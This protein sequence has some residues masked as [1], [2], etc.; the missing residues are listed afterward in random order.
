VGQ[1]KTAAQIIAQGLHDAG[2]RSAFGIPGGEVLTI[3]NALEEAGIS[4]VLTKHENPAGFMAEGTHHV[5]GAPGI[6]VAT[7]GPGVANAVNVVANA[8]QDRVPLIFLTGR[9]DPVDEQTYT[10]QV[11]DHGRLLDS[12]VK[13]SFTLVSGAVGTIVEKAVA[14]ATQGRPGPVHI[15]VPVSLAAEVQSSDLV[16]KPA[17]HPPLQPAESE[18]L[19]GA[20]DAFAAAT[21]PLLIVGLEAV[22]QGCGETI[23]GFA[24]THGIPVITTYKA[25]GLLPESDPLCLGA[26]GLSPLADKQLLPLVG[27]AD[28]ILL[29]GYDP[30][31]MRHG[32]KNPWNVEKTSVVE[33]THETHLHGVHRASYVFC[34]DIA[35]GLSVVT[36]GL[37]PR[38]SWPDGRPAQVRGA[39][40]DSFANNDAWGPAAIIQETRRA[41]PVDGIA[42]VDSGAHRILLSQIWPCEVPGTL[43]Q[44]TGLCTMGCALP[45]A[46]GAKLAAPDRAVVAF[47]G[48]AGL[49]M[50]LGEVAT[51]RDLRLPVVVVVFVDASLALIEMKQRNSGFPNQGVDFGKSDFAGLARVFGGQGFDV[52]TREEMRAALSNALQ[53]ETFSI[54]AA[55]IDAKAYDGTF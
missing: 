30:I 27:D 39:I 45:L 14:L 31:E 18:G 26:A 44:S 51:L 17:I 8:H 22:Q 34:G 46:M 48:D 24:R 33:L 35:A 41:L 19:S 54:I 16:A 29:A 28:F 50:I 40:Q 23:A 47:T 25:K 5:T 6:L 21:R 9:V 49:E 11:F 12:V 3:M 53:A 7:L 43:L 36:Q 52:E 13:G 2:C 38:A 42:T 15:D 10:H 4:F 20:R 32:W 37:A 1:T 55:H